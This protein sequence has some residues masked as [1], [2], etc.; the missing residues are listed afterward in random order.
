M[1]KLCQALPLIVVSHPLIERQSMICITVNVSQVM[2][3]I[4]ATHEDFETAFRVTI[5]LIRATIL[6][7]GKGMSRSLMANQTALSCMVMPQML[8]IK[9]DLI[10]L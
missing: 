7:I 1:G 10:N 2:M 8:Q 9:S 6:I 3:Q 5:M 4:I